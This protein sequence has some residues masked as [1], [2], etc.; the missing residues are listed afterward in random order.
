MSVLIES[1][2]RRR[3]KYVVTPCGQMPHEPIQYERNAVSL[4]DERL[5]KEGYPHGGKVVGGGGRRLGFQLSAFSR[6]L[7]REAR[8]NDTLLKADG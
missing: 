4:R 5:G 6:Q 2:L 1:R 7:R 3:D 8:Q